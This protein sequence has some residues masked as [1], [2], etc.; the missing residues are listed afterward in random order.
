MRP[1]RIACVR[2]GGSLTP[3]PRPAPEHAGHF[4]ARAGVRG[5]RQSFPPQ[6]CAAPAV[7][8][9]GKHRPDARRDPA[10][11]QC[12]L[13]DLQSCDLTR[14][15]THLLHRAG[16]NMIAI[17]SFSLPL[18]VVVWSP[19]PRPVRSTSLVFW[20]A[21]FQSLRV[22]AGLGRREHG[23]RYKK[24]LFLSRTIRETW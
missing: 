5:C 2:T 3:G 9:D 18:R 6:R 20:C 1:V 17:R 12:V 22:V 15:G 10:S 16:L 8:A 13:P 7:R 4:R 21:L 23:K 19:A 14:P 11:P 24:V